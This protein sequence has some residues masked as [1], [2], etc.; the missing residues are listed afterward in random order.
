M[1]VLFIRFRKWLANP[2]NAIFL[3]LLILYLVPIWCF[4]Y[5]PSADGPAHLANAHIMREFS[6]PSGAA[7]R[8]YYDWN[9]LPQPNWSG[10]L[11]MA[12]FMIFAPPLIAEKIL[13]SLYIL[14]LPISVRFV[15]GIIEPGARFL[16]ILIFPLVYSVPLHAGLYN[17]CCSLP[18]FFFTLGYWI[19]H[20][21]AFSFRNAINLGILLLILYFCH[22]ISFVM[23]GVAIM[24]LTA[25][26]LVVALKASPVRVS[27]QALG[28]GLREW[29]LLPLLAFVPGGLLAGAY[30]G[31]QHNPAIF[32]IP[33]AK[34]L[35]DLVSLYSLVTFSKVELI[36]S[37]SF[38]ALLSAL[39]LY[40]ILQRTKKRGCDRW[41]GLLLVTIMFTLIYF[42]APDAAAGGGMITPRMQLFPVFGLVLW[43]G[44]ATFTPA[45]K[46]GIQWS[47]VAI[48]LGG[49]IFY[50]LRYAELNRYIADFT[51]GAEL[52]ERNSTLY[53]IAFEFRG[54]RPD[55]T[56]L[57][58]HTMPFWQ[59]AGYISASRDAIDLL[60]YEARSPVFP[61][62]FRSERDPRRIGYVKINGVSWNPEP[63]IDFQKYSSES[64]GRV[65]Y[66]LVWML[67]RP[68]HE[69]AN[70]RSIFDQ[71][72]T[73]YELIHTSPLGY[74]K[75]YHRK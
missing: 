42:A 45:W 12:A 22:L 18:V 28:K 63:K 34:R 47:T 72:A 51:S 39:G 29:A 37:I 61:L 36:F 19:K 40:A 67:D 43:L 8:E 59:A 3:A 44:R 15:L 70:A 48:A 55:G 23:A 58:I 41:D 9:P 13:L 24:I 60:N 65:D 10:H 64:S 4:H 7:F 54:H 69:G 38:A 35:V 74:A 20:R 62:V 25:F 33:L 30:A 73:D 66:V 27:P 6:R 46:R 26:D 71:L 21:G 16:S 68:D 2:Q 50:T 53:P 17:F 49:L 57:S 14:L 56:A 5:F 52:I 11:L 75:L 32:S 31:H 1:Q